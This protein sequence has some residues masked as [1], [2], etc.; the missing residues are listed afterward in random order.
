MQ[1]QCRVLLL[2]PGAGGTI[3]GLDRGQRE[4]ESFPNR[5]P[6]FH[7]HGGPEQLVEGVELDLSA[8]M[9]ERYVRDSD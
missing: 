7:C 1:R 6:R 9:V 3:G 2:C 8:M 5:V 4:L